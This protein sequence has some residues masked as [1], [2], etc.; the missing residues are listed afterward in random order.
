MTLTNIEKGFEIQ[1]TYGVL[2][3]EEVKQFYRQEFLKLLEGL[4]MEVRPTIT[5]SEGRQG[6][7]TGIYHKGY[8][9]YNQAVEY[10]N[11]NIEEASK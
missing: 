4:K 5:Y 2:D 8:L 11:K 9:D 1:F 3:R 6:T 10:F 7:T